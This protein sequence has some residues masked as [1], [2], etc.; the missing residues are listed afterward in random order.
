MKLLI[1]F[2][3][4][5]DKRKLF[6]ILKTRKPKVYAIEIKEVNK[7]RSLDANKYY[8]AVLGIIASETGN[9]DNRLHKYFK[10][11]LL[12]KEEVKF[13]QTGEVKEVAKSTTELDKFDF[14]EY[15]E[16]IRQFALTD[17][18]IY[19]PTPDEF[20]NNE[21]LITQSFDRKI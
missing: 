1:N 17:L 6:E 2:G 7:K 19:V 10:D 9:T 11:E 5:P 4:E 18:N 13:P 8:W 14:Y 20:I 3:S 21:Q 12:A 16:R 15:V